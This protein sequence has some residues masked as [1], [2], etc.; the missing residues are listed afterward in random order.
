MSPDPANPLNQWLKSYPQYDLQSPVAV[1][2][3]GGPD[4]MALSSMALVWAQDND[5]EIHF[6][7]VDHEL[8]AEA[9]NEAQMVADWI[10]AQNYNKAYHVILSWEGNKPNTSIMEEART[11]RY[12]L[13][14]NYCRKKNIAQL[15]VAHHQDDQAETFLIRLSKG[16]GLDGLS[17]MQETRKYDDKIFIFRPL[18]NIAKQDLID[19]CQGNNVPFVADPS[20]E[21][22]KYLRPR[23]RQSM[24]V[25]T[26]EGLTPKR[27]SQ[28]AKRLSRARQALEEIA[29]KA[30]KD[31]LV[32]EKDHGI[33][34][35]FFKLRQY[36]EEIG[37]RVIQSS[38]ESL[39][40]GA[41][42]N[43]RMEKLEDLFENLWFAFDQFKPRTLGGCKFSLKSDKDNHDMTLWIEKEDLPV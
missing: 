35:S 31:C 17:C 40:V 22:K 2:V 42:Y 13:M 28:T 14:A 9:K 23:L 1:A 26:E 39:R 25:L 24:S 29:Y 33:V 19:Y 15:L 4:S 20:N 34:L 27:L 16:S 18:L 30:Q 32:E 21:N 37:F 36:P 7:T 3:S 41:S 43:A 8:R 12:E 6:V 38:M 5:A 10:A 11:A